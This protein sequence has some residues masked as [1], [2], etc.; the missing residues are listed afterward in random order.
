MQLLSWLNVRMTGRPQTRRAPAR[1]TPPRFRPR[2]EALETRDLPS[3][4]T[5]TNTLDSGPG[6]LRAEIAAAQPGDTI[7]FSPKL[8]NIHNGKTTTITLTSGELDL[9]KNLTIQGPGAGLLAVNG[10]RKGV[11]FQVE[12]QVALSGLTITGGG[13]VANSLGGGIENSGTLTVSDCTITQ[14]GTPNGGGGGIENSGTLTVSDC[15]ISQNGTNNG[16]GGIGNSGTLTVSDCTITQNVADSGGGIYNSGTLT[17]RDSTLSANCAQ[18]L[19]YTALQG[20]GGIYNSSGTLTA[21]GCT[22]YDNQSYYDGGG[23][24]MMSG[25][26]NLTNCTLCNNVALGSNADDGNGGGGGIILFGQTTV[27][28]TNCTLSLNA[29]KYGYGGGIFVLDGFFYPIL[30]L[31]NTIVAGNTAAGSSIQGGQD[32]L[33]PVATADHDL[34]GNATGSSGLV[35]GSGG[36]IVG[37]GF[38][39]VNA[40]LGPLQNNGGPTQTMALLAGSPAIGQADNAAAPATDQRGVTRLDAAGEATDIGAFEL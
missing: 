1:R 15:T 2:L 4:L 38:N 5:V 31:T 11:V 18:G 37:D 34:V 30:N 26:A 24:V 21:S 17:L 22:L 27:N 8:F 9:N 20:G 23:V 35:N 40:D 6:S 39:P 33:G 19:G 14:N 10:D 12:A 36:N 25:T 16:G 13:S 29:A 28:L 7:V 32:I 3:T